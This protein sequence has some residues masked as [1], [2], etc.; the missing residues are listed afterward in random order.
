MILSWCLH[1][2]KGANQ[3]G[4]PHWAKKSGCFFSE[5]LKP[6]IFWL[7]TNMADHGSFLTNGWFSF[8]LTENIYWWWFMVVQ[9][10][11]YKEVMFVMCLEWLTIYDQGVNNGDMIDWCWAHIPF[12]DKTEREAECC[13][14]WWFLVAFVKIQID[15][16]TWFIVTFVTAQIDISLWCFNNNVFVAM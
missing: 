3:W 5:H 12:L 2:V 14:T 10:I 6:Q 9:Y 7:R 1:D 15:V 13:Y 8:M 4:H 11:L 16:L